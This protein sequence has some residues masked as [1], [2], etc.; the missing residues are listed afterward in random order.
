VSIPNLASRA[1]RH[2]HTELISGRL[3]P[4]AVISEKRLA[5]ELGI[6][7]TPVGDAVRRLAD[8]GFVEQV[9]R[10][11][12]LVKEI[13]RQDIVEVYE[14][15][16]AIEPYAAS[17]AASQITEKQLG[18]LSI[19]YEAINKLVV[20]FNESGAT[21]LEGQELRR[22]L[23]ADMEFHLLILRAASNERMLK[24]ILS[25]RAVSQVFRIRR[26]RHDSQLIHRACEF[27]LSI[28]EALRAGN[29]KE[30][31]IRMLDHICVSKNE[32]LKFIDEQHGRKLLPEANFSLE[33]DEEVR[34]Q[35]ERLD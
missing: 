5:E 25:S 8:E 7:R 16:E 20:G 32:T 34:S 23:A 24:C 6:S 31:G 17:K 13:T 19:L 14:L 11:G 10:Y 27:H 15:R 2:I 29:G 35:L 28:L 4:G 18:Q 21:E 12:T 22:F 30:A 3:L 33:L 1:Y 9:P 26:Q